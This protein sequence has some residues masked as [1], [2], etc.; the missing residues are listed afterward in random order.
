MQAQ[1]MEAVGRLAGGV[2]HD[3]NNLLTV[4]LGYAGCS[5]GATAR[6]T[7]PERQDVAEIQ[8]AARAATQ[9][10]RQLLAFSR[11]AG[12]STPRP[13]DPR[14]VV[15]DSRS[16]MLRRLIGEDVE[17]VVDIAG[18]PR[19]DHGRPEPA[20]AGAGESRAQRPRR[21]ALR[22]PADDRRHARPRSTRISRRA[23]RGAAWAAMS[24]DDLRHGLW[25]DA[26]RLRNVVRAVLHDEGAGQGDRP[27]P[28]H[29]AGIVEQSNGYVEVESEP[30]ARSAFR[31]YLPKVAA[32]PEERL[33]APADTASPQGSGS[34][35][36]LEDEAPVRSL[37]C[38]ILREAG[39]TVLE[40]ATGEEAL[41]IEASHTGR[42]DLL[43]TDVVLPDMN[44]HQVA[45]VLRRRRPELP[46]LYAS[47]Y[48]HEMI[49]TR[50]GGSEPGVGYLPKPYRPEELLGR[51]RELLGSAG[52]SD[53]AAEG[54]GA[55]EGPAAG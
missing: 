4:I 34:L 35:L 6:R 28:R 21:H 11:T 49:A 3:F 24:S 33:E 18:R 23:P 29:R 40:A 31:I 52:A 15:N 39:Y 5:P 30:R 25:H 54:P 20:G 45:D 1:K 36:V 13:L 16:P 12:A 55:G 14:V 8:R 47:G 37:A 26:G 48:D 51:I 2:A 44:G 27:R 10:T 43:F 17:L 19:T 41:A 53:G 50:A 22:G 42:I 46:V 9:L 38:R 32:A 7:T